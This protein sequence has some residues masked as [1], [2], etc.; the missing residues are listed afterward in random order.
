MRLHT[1]VNRP[2][3]PW[4]SLSSDHDRRMP[5]PTPPI[6]RIRLSHSGQRQNKNPKVK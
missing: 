5:I 4:T 6:L 1:R 2:N 3:Q